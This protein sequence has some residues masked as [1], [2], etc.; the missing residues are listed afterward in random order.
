MNIAVK[1]KQV[2]WGGLTTSHKAVKNL[3]LVGAISII[4]VGQD[5]VKISTLDEDQFNEWCLR[6]MEAGYQFGCD[7]PL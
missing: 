7:I 4:T 6:L 5:Q 2:G 3:N 1:E